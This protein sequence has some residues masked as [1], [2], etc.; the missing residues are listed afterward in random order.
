ML[1]LF[2]LL[3]N[4]QRHFHSRRLTVL[5]GRPELPLLERVQHKLRLRKQ[6]RED[7]GE[8]LEAAILADKAVIIRTSASIAPAGMSGRTMLYGQ[9]AS[10]RVAFPA[11]AASSVGGIEYWRIQLF[12]RPTCR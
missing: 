4:N 6:R 1:F 2:R 11:A 7:D 8:R 5:R 10:T 9:G 3:G 12:V